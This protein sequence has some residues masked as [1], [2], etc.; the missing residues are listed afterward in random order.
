MS[1]LNTK[2]LVYGFEKG[3]MKEEIDLVF[4]YPAKVAAMLLNDEIDIGLVPVAVLP[5]LKE[6]TG[7]TSES[8]DNVAVLFSSLY[9]YR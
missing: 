5:K 8:F 3:L 6:H 4:D 2:P 9:D 7:S 1:Y